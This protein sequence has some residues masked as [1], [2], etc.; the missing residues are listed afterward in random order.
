MLN[1]SNIRNFGI[2]AHIDAGKTTTTER[3][4][5]LTGYTHKI[6][7][8]DEGTT[9][10][11]WMT[12]ER[13]R[14][15]TITA[16]SVSCVWSDAIFHI[17]DTP[18]HVDFTAEVQRSLRILDGAVV[19]FCAVGGVQTQSET[20]WKQADNFNIPKIIFI[21]KLDRLGANFENVLDEIN[22]KLNTKYIVLSIP[23]YQKENLAG[24]IDIINMKKV[25]FKDDGVIDSVSE[26]P[27]DYMEKASK[28][29]EKLIDVLTNYDD[30]LLELV[31]QE[32]ASVNDIIESIRRS[33]IKRHFVPVLAGAS[34]KNIGV[35][36][37]LDAIKNY[38]PSPD[39][40]GFINGYFIKKDKWDKITFDDKAFP[41]VYV[42]K[43]QYNRE[44]GIIAFVRIYSGTINNGD[45]LYN[46]RTK[47]KERIHDL[48]RSYADK[49]ERLETA[50]AG[51]IVTL[52]GFKNIVTGDTL[53]SEGNQVILETLKFPEPVIFQ[54]IE[55]KNSL[56]KDKLNSIMQY[57][58]LEDPTITYKDDAHTG[59]T[60]I[61]GMGELH[62]Q[63]FVERIKNSY[64]IEL[65]TGNPYVSY[66]ETPNGQGEFTFEFDKKI[67]GN[68][69]HAVIT[70]EVQPNERNK[71]NIVKSEL[72][73][74]DSELVANIEK[75]INDALKS[76]PE[77]AYPV[78][79][80]IIIIK[81]IVYDA[82]RSTPLAL[83]AAANL[84]TSNLLRKVGTTL[85]EPIMKIEI[86]LPG[87]YTGNVIGELQSRGGIIL[88]IQKKLEQE[89]ITASA[90]LRV[91]FGYTTTL[92][93]LT[94]GKGSFT[95]EFMYYDKI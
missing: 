68:V 92:R 50:K 38:L 52:A 9:I 49:F 37:L 20:V 57:L 45:T 90:P 69:Q 94:Q 80:T 55:P 29:R 31:L 42:F 11:D 10:T 6:G 27:E 33:T 15:I 25:N 65:K 67:E 17:I 74:K 28:Y 61:G 21:N 58:L 77:G 78:I 64:G 39:D 18:G 73:K 7:E 46:P 60:L 76:G 72:H 89:N 19:V 83:E 40:I 51:D 53:C 71:G 13:E 93:S 1:S 16:A 70:L 41:V 86:D 59:Q 5:Y 75:G 14:G 48:L 35:P 62:I 81:S 47:K 88:D 2:I 84:C 91:M 63:I 79:D 66:R 85:L 8:V 34:L 36:P 32:K 95:M 4:L 3:I 43:V 30:R 87:E 23:Y 54:R 22:N 56:D 12:E 82:S 26:I 24:I 44:K